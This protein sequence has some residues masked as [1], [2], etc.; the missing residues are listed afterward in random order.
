MYKL[1]HQEKTY[2]SELKEVTAPQALVEEKR[3]DLYLD[4]LDFMQE[5]EEL[6]DEDDL[7]LVQEVDVAK[8][9]SDVMRFLGLKRTLGELSRIRYN[10]ALS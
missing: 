1:L 9:K 5:A 6:L 8:L 7:V 2:L 4:Y 10:P 3:L